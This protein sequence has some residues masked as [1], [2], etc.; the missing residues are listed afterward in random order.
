MI[1]VAKDLTKSEN[2]NREHINL[3]SPMNPKVPCKQSYGQSGTLCSLKQKQA[4]I[5]LNDY[6]NS[7][8]NLN[9]GF[10][11]KIVS[12]S[13]PKNEYKNLNNLIKSDEIYGFTPLNKIL[14]S[15]TNLNQL[16]TFQGNNKNNTVS[17]GKINTKNNNNS[18]VQENKEEQ[19]LIKQA[20][21]SYTNRLPPVPRRNSKTNINNSS[22]NLSMNNSLKNINKLNASMISNRTVSSSNVS[23][24]EGLSPII[25]PYYQKL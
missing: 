1:D 9:N 10:T 20:K 14:K 18:N 24:S 21:D 16:S 23:N 6:S 19:K 4:L 22:S 3:L 17:K 5:G 8:K 2:E 7:I 11:S 15:E 12:F 13:S 25:K